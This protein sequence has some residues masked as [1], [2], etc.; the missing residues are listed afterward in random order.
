MDLSK[1][2]FTR[3]E[4][5]KFLKDFEEIPVEHRLHL[6]TNAILCL[7]NNKSDYLRLR[8]KGK[9]LERRHVD[10]CSGCDTAKNKHSRVLGSLIIH[11]SSLEKLEGF[12]ISTFIEPFCKLFFKH[13]L[14]LFEIVLTVIGKLQNHNYISSNCQLHMFCIFLVNWCQHWFDHIPLMPHTLLSMLDIMLLKADCEL[15]QH[16]ARRGIRARNYAW[17]WLATAFQDVIIDNSVLC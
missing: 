14:A 12:D 11:C 2:V 15:Y 6:W 13:E 4:V 8:E 17:K 7:P 3:E 9:K 1:P 16:L 5:L 10:A